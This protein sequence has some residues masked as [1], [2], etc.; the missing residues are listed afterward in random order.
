MSDN[1][2]PGFLALAKGVA[3][4]TFPHTVDARAWAD[5]W[6]KTFTV[7]PSI[8][9]DRDTMIGWFANA[10][11]AGYDTAQQRTSHA[12]APAVTTEECLD[13]LKAVQWGNKSDSGRE[14]CPACWRSD[15]IGHHA[16]CPINALL[17]RAGRGGQS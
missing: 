15:S 14:Y 3:D 8:A 5:E 10:I 7:N 12:P 6:L 17:Q 4:Q 16:T 11:M 13:A 1:E 9:S 2:L